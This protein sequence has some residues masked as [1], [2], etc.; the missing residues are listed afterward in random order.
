MN[1]Q[2]VEVVKLL[3]PYAVTTLYT[4]GYID[5]KG[6]INPG[7]RNVKAILLAGTS[8]TSGTCGG[9]IQSAEDTAG[10]GLTTDHTFTGLTSAGGMEEGHFR[11]PANHRYVRYLATAQ[12]GKTM[13]LS[14]VLLGEAYYRP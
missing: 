6:L 12:S 1:M 10:T 2:A 3:Q 14:V 9:S 13:E 5:C 4:G 8:S 7:G 11:I